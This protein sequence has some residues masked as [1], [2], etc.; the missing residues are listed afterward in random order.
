MV[1]TYHTYTLHIHDFPT[2]R[3]DM[4]CMYYYFLGEKYNTIPYLLL[5]LHNKLWQSSR[6]NWP[7]HP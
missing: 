6:S 2:L 5:L 4:V 7:F 1:G 3:Y